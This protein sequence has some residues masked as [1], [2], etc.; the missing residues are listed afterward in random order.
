MLFGFSDKIEGI[1]HITRGYGADLPVATN[2]A[3]KRFYKN[4]RVEVWIK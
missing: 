4:R 3:N 2:T 1:P